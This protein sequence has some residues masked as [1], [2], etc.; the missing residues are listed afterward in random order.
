M[1]PHGEVV[2]DVFENDLSVNA[3]TSPSWAAIDGMAQYIDDSLGILS[4]STPYLTGFYAVF[5][6]YTSNLA[7]SVSL[8][9]HLEVFR[10]TA[11]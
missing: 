4:G 10:Q 9:D 11:P 2:L 8:F 3:V 5:G 1:N 7:G 6:H